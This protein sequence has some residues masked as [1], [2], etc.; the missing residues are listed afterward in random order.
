MAKHRKKK[1]AARAALPGP[2]RSGAPTA[3]PPESELQRGLAAFQRGDYGEAIR[4]WKQAR[5]A[6]TPGAVDLV[7]AEAHFRY[8]MATTNE[9]RRAQELHEAAA[10]APDRAVYHFHLALAYHRQG[11]LRRAIAAYETAHRLAPGDDRV[12]RHLALAC[13]ADPATV[14]RVHD[15]LAGASSGDEATV[16]LRALAALRENAPAHAVAALATLKRPS[17][18]AGLALGLAQLGDGQ[19]EAAVETLAKV[20]RSRRPEG[21]TARQ[22]A[23]IATVVA[24]TRAG[25]LT[26]ALNLLRTL[27]AP[28]SD[29]LRR[30]LAAAGRALGR[31]LV[32]DER[33]EEA[34]LA[35]QR[36]AVAEP[37]HEPSRRALIHLHEVLGAAAARRGDFAAAARHWEAT[38]AEQ[39]DSTRILR[40]LA[41]AEERLERWEQAG[42]HW[43]ELTRRWKKDLRGARRDDGAAAELRQ[44]LMVAY[45]RLAAAQEAAGDMPTAARTLEQALNFDPADVD[46]R[47]RAA[48]L[49]LEDERYGAAIEH[50]HR[51]LAARPNDTRVWIDVGWAY[52]LKGDDRQAQSYLERAL[53]LEP[54]NQATRSV[55]AG[56]H[57]GRDHRLLDAGQADRAVAELVRARELD[58]DAAEHSECLG[59]AYL[60][61][62]RLDAARDAFGRSLALTPNDPK[63]RVTIGGIY[64]AAG[65]EREAEK[66]FRQALRLNRGPIT[67]L[68]IGLAY[69][70]AGRQAGA[71]PHFQRVVKGRDPLL[72]TLLGKVFIEA[73]REEEAIPYL[74]LALTLD[75]TSVRARLDLAWAYTFGRH[76]YARA[77]TEIAAA[78]RVARAMGDH[79]A[80]GEIANAREALA[81]LNEAA[82]SPRR[83]GPVGAAWR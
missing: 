38:L 72:L 66:L 1:Q 67:H 50:L 60:K 62:G 40:N 56:V 6:G 18:L 70:R 55:L 30:A 5:R 29:A 23:A 24:Q 52:D 42:A 73:K 21:A 34:M 77:A 15:L 82:Q 4:A 48:E 8:A 17:P 9:A 19:A 12:R 79:A 33:A 81:V 35:W 39:P 27:D 25:D 20:R 51:V 80:L 2:I 83:A 71:E 61:L 53:S 45:R 3:A 46:L 14:P 7:L 57:H 43:E 28:D 49:Y 58:P 22:A 16:R 78:E 69:F 41:L 32:L 36:A 74:E 10:L 64:L 26:A 11:Q 47:L 63:S 75:P 37:G 68:A 31:E 65:H 59:E 76:D 13:L 54:E 44:R